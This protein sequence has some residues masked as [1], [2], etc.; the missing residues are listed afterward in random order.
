MDKKKNLGIIL[1]GVSILILM[2]N[3]TITG[4]TIGSFTKI[5]SNIIAIAFLIGGLGLFLSKKKKES[6]EE[7]VQTNEPP[8][9]KLSKKARQ[10]ARKDKT[11]RN[12]LTKYFGEIKK[13]AQNPLNRPREQIGEFQVSPQGQIFLRIPWYYDSKTN[14]LYIYDFLYHTKE[15]NYTDNW[16]IKVKQGKIKRQDYHKSENDFKE[17]N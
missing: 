11:V 6:L 4:A 7:K 3:L 9:I 2:F 10:R 17:L 12:N 8:K 5:S 1:V 16:N 13:I 15:K 14:T